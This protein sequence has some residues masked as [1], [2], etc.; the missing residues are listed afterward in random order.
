MAT[1]T[2]RSSPSGAIFARKG[3]IAVPQTA[4][5]V[6]A[7]ASA[8]CAFQG[9]EVHD[10]VNISPRAALQGG[11]AI[12]AAW[13]S[14][15]NVITLQLINVGANATLTAQTMDATVWTD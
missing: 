10:V 11:I 14:A 4:V 1:D 9:A 3:T 7:S 8:T 12:A 2:Y 15:A 5:G 13:V 6:T